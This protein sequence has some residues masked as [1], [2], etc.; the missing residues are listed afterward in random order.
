MALFISGK[1]TEQVVEEVKD[2]T[3]KEK[4]ALYY[5]EARENRCAFSQD[6]LKNLLNYDP[7]TGD[8]TWLVPRGGGFGLGDKAGYLIKGK[9][10]GYLAILVKGA[11]YRAH[12]LAWFYMTGEWV[13]K[14]LEVDHKDRN[15]SNNSWSNLRKATG[16][17]NCT[18]TGLH[19]KNVSGVRGVSWDTRSG[20]W[21]AR[22]RVNKKQYYLGQYTTVEEAAKVRKEAEQKYYAEIWNCN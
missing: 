1:K 18:N 20:K 7:E 17:Q 15:R 14:P 5:K 11:R 10:G 22:I 9:K 2:L 16:A 6:E 12:T 13:R 4:K 19:G 3:R 21:E 8:I